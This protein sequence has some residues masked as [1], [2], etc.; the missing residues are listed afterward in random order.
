MKAL[1]RNKQTIYYANFLGESPLLDENGLDTGEPVLSYSK[2]KAA[3]VNVSASRGTANVDLFGTDIN[4]TN[5]IVSDTDLGID[6]HSLI[7]YGDACKNPLYPSDD[8]FPRDDL[9]PNHITKPHNYIV[10]SVAK[11]LNSVT[12]AIRKVDVS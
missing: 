4:Y 6:E 7:W 10:V 8:L 11:S 12:Y 5:T 9:F 2:L 3:R 1:N